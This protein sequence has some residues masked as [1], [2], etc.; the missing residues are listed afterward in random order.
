MASVTVRN[1]HKE[2]KGAKSEH[3]FAHGTLFHFLNYIMLWFRLDFDFTLGLTLG[4]ELGLKFGLGLG[5]GL[6]LGQRFS[7]FYV[8]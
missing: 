6:W 1:A 4:L 8:T 3:S 2:N 7:Y 5:L